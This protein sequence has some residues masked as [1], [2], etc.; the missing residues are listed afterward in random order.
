MHKLFGHNNTSEILRF[1]FFLLRTQFSFQMK[2]FLGFP[3]PKY[4]REHLPAEVGPYSPEILNL[5]QNFCGFDKSHDKN[6]HNFL[7]L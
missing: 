2:V 1:F 7:L 3:V 4:S 5:I 6:L